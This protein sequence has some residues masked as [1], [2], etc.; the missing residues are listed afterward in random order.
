MDRSKFEKLPTENMPFPPLKFFLCMDFL[1]TREKRGQVWLFDAD[2]DGFEAAYLAARR[3]EKRVYD[4]SQARALP[5]SPP[6]FEQQNEWKMRAASANFFFDRAAKTG[7]WPQKI[8]DLGCGN[9]WFTRLL[10]EKFDGET[11]GLDVNFEELEQAARLFSGE[12]TAFAHGDIFRADL[13][14]RHF[15]A[16][17]LNASAQYFEDFERLGERLL[18]L[19]SE[20]KG[21]RVVILDTPFYSKKEVTAARERSRQHY[22]LTKNERMAERYFH[23]SWAELAGFEWNSHFGGP[24]FFEKWTEKSVRFFSNETRPP[25]PQIE[26]LGKRK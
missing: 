5:F 20:K 8:L 10:A 15:D 24:S 23:R 21:S 4:D 16:I 2:D 22:F 26:I 19:L 11:L 6:V 13:P 7:F 9:G 14:E 12:K 3:A 1:K 17:F 25:F 18:A